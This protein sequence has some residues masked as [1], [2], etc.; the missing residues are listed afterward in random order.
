ML[1]HGGAEPEERSGRGEAQSNGQTA[2]YWSGQTPLRPYAQRDTNQE[3]SED[4]PVPTYVHFA[5]RTRLYQKGVAT[6]SYTVFR[7][8]GR[9]VGQYLPKDIGHLLGGPMYVMR[10]TIF[11]GERRASCDAWDTMTKRIAWRFYP[12]LLA[13]LG[14][15]VIGLAVTR[16]L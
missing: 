6:V 10:V 2:A 9:G 7:A 5:P 12:L 16:V 11:I 13:C 1:A 15:Y 4:P 3:S 8:E 14:G